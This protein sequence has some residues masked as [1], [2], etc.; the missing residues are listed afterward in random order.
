MDAELMA[1]AASGAT[2][3]VQQMAADSWTQA[4]DHI[5][6]F[7]ARNRRG[8]EAAIEGELETSRSELTMAVATGDEQ[9]AA[10]VEALW[11]TQ[12]RRL[13]LAEPTAAAQL[14]A[15]LSDLEHVLEGRQVTSVQNTISG[16]LQLGPV[17]Q[18][19]SVGPL[20]FGSPSR[21]S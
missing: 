19:G 8:E 20:N 9:T 17:I 16:G 5:V 6:A 12:L 15:V 1:L 13:L 7:F 11:R 4:R 10:D 2:V 14:R 3:L 21:Q 18:A